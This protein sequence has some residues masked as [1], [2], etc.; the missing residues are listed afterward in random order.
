MLRAEPRSGS[1]VRDSLYGHRYYAPTLG[2][3]ISRDPIE[4]RGGL[5]LVG[6][7]KNAPVLYVDKY[8]L[9]HWATVA[10]GGLQVAS[11]VMMWVVA[12]AGEIGSAGMATPIAY[13]LGIWGSLN[14]ASGIQS[15][16]AGLND[17]GPPDA[18]QVQIAEQTYEALFGEPMSPTGQ[19]FTRAAVYTID[20]V[21]ACYTIS[22]SWKTMMEKGIIWQAYPEIPV[23][24]PSG[25]EVIK[26]GSQLE[27]YGHVTGA[28]MQ[29]FDVAFDYYGLWNSTYDLSSGAWELIFQEG[30]SQFGNGGGN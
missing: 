12:G 26:V 19:Q 17:K 7:V 23:T 11:G 25:V 2:R 28:G 1:K 29:A 13:G 15:L 14:I 5:N 20:I 4:E 30:D 18:V 9:V 24:T 6:F 3:W 16:A 21:C 10:Q 27:F 8:G 22:I